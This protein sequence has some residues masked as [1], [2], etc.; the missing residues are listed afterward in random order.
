MIIY[1]VVQGTITAIEV[2]RET[3]T[4]WTRNP[5]G[6]IKRHAMGK[7]PSLSDVYYT[8]S[9]QL[10]M[11]WS[12]IL[13]ELLQ[14]RIDSATASQQDLTNYHLNGA[15]GAL[16]T[17]RLKSYKLVDGYLVEIGSDHE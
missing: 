7:Y 9:Y 6:F 11:K 12:Q 2:L 5:R 13:K 1:K 10:A 3:D 8:S 4:G 15:V 16:P 14:K 17:S